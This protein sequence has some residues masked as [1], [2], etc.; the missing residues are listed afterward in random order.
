MKSCKNCKWSEPYFRGLLCHWV[1]K[2]SV[3][4]LP[5]YLQIVGTK[6]AGLESCYPKQIDNNDYGEKCRVFEEGE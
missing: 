3:P 4:A 2:N 6:L 5:A 1:E